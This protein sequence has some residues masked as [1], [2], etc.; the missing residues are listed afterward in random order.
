MI[1]KLAIDEW[2]SV[3]PWTDRHKDA[4]VISETEG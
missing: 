3:V 4:C 1:P 2:N